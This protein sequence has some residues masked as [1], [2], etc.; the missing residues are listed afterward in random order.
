VQ[1]T[2]QFFSHVFCGDFKKTPGNSKKM[3]GFKSE[4]QSIFWGIPFPVGLFALAGWGDPHP[5][6]ASDSQSA[7]LTRP[8]KDGEQPKNTGKKGSPILFWASYRIGFASDALAGWGIPHPASARSP[9]GNG[10]VSKTPGI[11]KK[12]LGFKSDSDSLFG[13]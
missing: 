13:N 11:S 12:M 6:S 7:A 10:I 2:S 4:I 5:A 3:L 9:T 1:A 8:K